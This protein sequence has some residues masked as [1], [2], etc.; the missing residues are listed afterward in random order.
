MVWEETRGGAT[1]AREVAHADDAKH[2]PDERSGLEPRA[3]WLV[4]AL[5]GTVLVVVAGG[6]TAA[7]VSHR[8]PGPAPRSR[9]SSPSPGGTTQ[10]SPARSGLA[11]D[12]SLI[13]SITIQGTAHGFAKPYLGNPGSRHDAPETAV[14]RCTPERCTG[15]AAGLEDVL[16]R[17]GPGSYRLV[18]RDSDSSETG[19]LNY[20]T[21]ISLTVRGSHGTYSYTSTGGYSG[22]PSG[23]YSD[24]PPQGSV[25][26]GPVTFS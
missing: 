21:T 1:V 12:G 14:F 17:V 26:T 15:G 10:P 5:V 18:R 7:V 20:T 13:G 6:T 11:P 19:P 8:R 24:H 25:L 3:R 22:N 9:G 2:R 4:P 23:R 16:V